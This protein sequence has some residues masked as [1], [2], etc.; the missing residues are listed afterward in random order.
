MELRSHDG[1]VP[2]IEAPP[3]PL[4]RHCGEVKYLD[5]TRRIILGSSISTC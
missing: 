3:P 2:V 4:A 1:S 5:G